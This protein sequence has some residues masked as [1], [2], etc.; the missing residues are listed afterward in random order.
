MTRN[1]NE[2]E[3]I[4]LSISEYETLE[5]FLNMNRLIF[6]VAL[7]TIRNDEV[8][9]ERLSIEMDKSRRQARPDDSYGRRRQAGY[10]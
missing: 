4:E 5:A 9:R 2:G 10:H 3:Q 8:Q 6:Y 7:A 1:K